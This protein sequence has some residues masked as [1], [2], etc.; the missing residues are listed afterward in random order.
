[1]AAPLILRIITDASQ[2]LRE[3]DKVIASNTL[4]GES[5]LGMGGDFAK[6]AKVQVATTA[7]VRAD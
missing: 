1:M 2:S 3:N 5:A 4:V 7:K 6:A